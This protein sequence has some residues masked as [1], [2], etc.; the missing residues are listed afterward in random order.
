MPS[1][2]GDKAESFR[3]YGAT[4]EKAWAQLPSVAP[5]VKEAPG[6]TTGGALTVL[7]VAG[8]AIDALKVERDEARQESESWQEFLGPAND[9]IEELGAML[10]QSGH[11]HD[12]VLL[13]AGQSQTTEDYR[14]AGQNILRAVRALLDENTA[15][16]KGANT[17]LE[18]AMRVVG[19]AASER[20]AG[21]WDAE[22][23]GE[24][25]MAPWSR[26]NQGPRDRLMLSA[27]TGMLEDWVRA[28]E[29]LVLKEEAPVSAFHPDAVV[30]LAES[31]TAGQFH[32]YTCANRNDG[33]HRHMLGDLGALVP[34][35]RGWICPFC[36]YTQ[37]WA[38]GLPPAG[39][40]PAKKE[41]VAPRDPEVKRHEIE[42]AAEI[43]ALH[44]RAATSFV[45]RKMGI[46]YARAAAIMEKL[47]EE[48][49]VSEANHVGK[50]DVLDYSALENAAGVRQMVAPR[51]GEQS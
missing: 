17:P 37:D 22:I 45:Q 24:E 36:D 47:I 6:L 2:G 35:V 50:R 34:T 21:D 20:A 41:G 13:E 42:T 39:E 9:C 43:V 48:G 4:F 29:H 25:G 33:N 30:T 7:K 11:L 1:V 19:N 26:L 28:G 46:S 8:D 10:I 31:Q 23:E 15:L 51:E 16:K 12:G 27:L 44:D 18:V 14:L 32:P 5:H 40:A 3:S 49:V 38:H